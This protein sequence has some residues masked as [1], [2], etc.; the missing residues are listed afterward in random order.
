MSKELPQNSTATKQ[1]IINCVLSL[2]SKQLAILALDLCAFSWIGLNLSFI[3][4]TLVYMPGCYV[5]PNWINIL[6]GVVLIFGSVLAG[7]A[8]KRGRL[9]VGVLALTFTWSFI[10][11]VV[12]TVLEYLSI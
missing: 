3:R 5:I 9:L 11:T 12:R 2:D 4:G 10:A 1:S 8:V 7:L 6:S